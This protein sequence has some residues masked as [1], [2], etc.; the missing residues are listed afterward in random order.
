MSIERALS[1]LLTAA[2]LAIAAIVVRREFFPSSAPPHP[3]EQAAKSAEYITGWEDWLETGRRT[4]AQE[5]DITILEFSD[6]EC[7]FCRQFH[8]TVREAQAR[9]PGRVAHVF[10]HYPLAFHRFARP[11]ARGAECACNQGLFS[12]FVH[13][14]FEGQNSLGLKSWTSF[15]VAA[16]IPDT[17]AFSRCAA[18][19]TA[20]PAVEAGR[21]LGDSLGVRG[22]PTVVVNG[23]RLA[24]PPSAKELSI[25]IERVMGGQ[26]P[27]AESPG[28]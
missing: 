11:A 15:A 28:N 12:E 18:D 9:Y 14:V 24:L 1:V 13:Q 5:A 26:A 6:L 20:V 7:P 23:W 8:S 4:G 25:I 21:A 3:S 2:T 16:G 27:F 19:T 10:V 22:T 17:S